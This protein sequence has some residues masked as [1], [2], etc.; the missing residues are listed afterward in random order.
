MSLAGLLEII[1]TVLNIVIDT[2][3][4]SMLPKLMELHEIAYNLP[5]SKK[6]EKEISDKAC[7]I[8]DDLFSLFGGVQEASQKSL[9]YRMIVENFF[10]KL[11][12]FKSLIQDVRLK[13]L[14]EDYV[15]KLYYFAE[16]I[17]GL[18]G[19]VINNYEIKKK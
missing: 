6:L 11:N 18:S 10:P 15:N 16:G 1:E 7:E 9:K 14:N 8:S 5:K 13:K 3:T 17:E 12:H 19:F 2:Y 4:M